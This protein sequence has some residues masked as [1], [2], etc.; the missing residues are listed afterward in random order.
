MEWSGSVLLFTDA[1]CLHNGSALCGA[2]VDLDVAFPS[3]VEEEVA[4][5][6]GALITDI[7][8]VALY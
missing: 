5:G 6:V 3:S 4:R 2:T 7:A 8:D 1:G